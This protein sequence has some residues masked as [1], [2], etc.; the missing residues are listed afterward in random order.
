MYLSELLVITRMKLPIFKLTCP[1]NM[2]ELP[3]TANKLEE[4]SNMGGRKQ[5]AGAT[6]RH[7]LD[8]KAAF[9]RFRNTMRRRT[10][11]RS[12]GEC[13]HLADTLAASRSIELVPNASALLHRYWMGC[14]TVYHPLSRLSYLVI[15]SIIT[16]RIVALASTQ[17]KC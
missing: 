4:T 2:T 11:H 14:K 9:K 5:G 12:G 6:Q 13:A 15:L 10:R 1:L 3:Y 7:P 16:K 17:P 8:S